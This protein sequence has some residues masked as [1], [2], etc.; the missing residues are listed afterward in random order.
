MGCW[1]SILA[2][3]ILISPVAT[4]AQAIPLKLHARI[5]QL[6]DERNLNG[7]ELT[8]GLKMKSAAVRERVALA[9]G[10]I[11]DRRATPS[12]IETLERDQVEA[13]RRMA[14]FALGEIEDPR[15]V[16]ALLAVVEKGSESPVLRGRAAEALG[17]INDPANLPRIAR[18]LIGQ[19]PA[20][21]RPLSDDERLL[22]TLTVAAL[23]RGR[24]PDAVGPLTRLLKSSDAEIRA[25]AAN[26][27]ARI[28]LPLG[29]AIE[30]LLAVL[31]DSDADVRANAARALGAAK[32]ARA[33]ELLLASL[34]DPSDRVQASAI[35]ALGG[36][37]DNRIVEPLLALGQKL[38][39]QID[40]AEAGPAPQLK[41]LL[42]IAAVLGAVKDRRA[43]PFLAELR[44]AEGVGAYPEIEVAIAAF[45]PEAFFTEPLD[46]ML[47]DARRSQG[48]GN[49][50]RGLGELGDDQSRE[51]LLLL[52]G[53]EPA[54]SISRPEILRALAKLKPRSLQL[55]L[56][57]A[58]RDKEIAPRATAADLI[59]NSIDQS[60]MLALI[61]GYLASE[62]DR[63]NDAK[64]A[65]LR[66]LAKYQDPPAKQILQA[67]TLDRDHLVRRL[68]VELLRQQGA[69]DFANRI[70]T[71][72]TDHT[73]AYYLRLAQ[74]V[75]RKI[76]A[77]IRTTKG[78]VQLM[79]FR[80]DAPATVESFVR[81]ARKGY[82]NGISFHRVV[83]NFV[84]QGGD[85]RG[86]G[87]GG[88]GYQIRC[89]INT[90]P[91]RRGTLG[92]ALSGKDTGGSQF[93]ITHSPQPHLDGGYTVFGQVVRSQDVVDGISRGDRIRSVE[94]VESR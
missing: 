19:L 59:A 65:I 42:E 26:A 30:P 22:A 8:D 87:D 24:S 48:V 29:D 37:A 58:L 15:A 14:A 41:L 27:L 25:H 2:A 17:K 83:P 16:P 93:F 72:Q 52:W 23:M 3:I 80:Q 47:D 73:P 6:E 34:D 31:R 66:A 46:R 40:R 68:A 44:K 35:R 38:M 77:V 81:L 20:S 79:L 74:Q 33:L 9:L 62:E 89:E 88:P 11:G 43:L 51:L 86:S 1:L 71:V 53:S 60:N 94:I 7:S 70:G 45:G 32:D 50:A 36:F 21:D 78:T 28:R 55:L 18:A 49:F 63:D 92:M 91:Y 75:D 13:V 5:L 69:G 84:V 54:D 4:F 90:Q 82:F 76:H 67:G 39:K 57:Q 64:L 85:P 10:R 61:R 56:H 12:L